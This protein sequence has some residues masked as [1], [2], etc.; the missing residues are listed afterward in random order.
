MNCMVCCSAAT[1]ILGNPAMNGGWS[2]EH[3]RT[4]PWS[5]PKVWGQDADMPPLFTGV[6]VALVTLFSDDGALDTWAT[7]DHAARLVELGVRSVLVAGTTGEASTLTVE[8]RSELISAVRTAVPAGVP[9]LAGTGAAT[10]HQAAG[11]TERAFDAGA[12]AVLA[13]SPPRVADPRAYYD[14]VAKASTGPLLA[15]HFPA[16]SAPGIPVHR[17]PDL[18]VSGLKDSSGDAGRLLDQVEVFSGDLYTGSAPLLALGAAVGIAGA[19]LAL[20]NVAP[21]SCAAAFAGDGAAQA[22]LAAAHRAASADFPAGI[23][24]LVAQR[25]GVSTVARLGG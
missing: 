8:E 10:G 11:L 25:F 3:S 18:P 6:G 21:E 24:G 19:I 7:A 17:L 9:V 12:D 2:V 23:K 1:C 13:L 15:Y 14:R 20:A 5:T 16:A 22:G 4:V